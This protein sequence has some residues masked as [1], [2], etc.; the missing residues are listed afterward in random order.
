VWE[1]AVKEIKKMESAHDRRTFLER[2]SF[3]AAVLAS[4]RPGAAATASA[5]K[6]LAGVFPIGFSPFTAGDKLDLDGLASQVKF[7][8][9]GGVRG[10]VWPQIAS[11]WTTLSEKERLDGAEAIVAAGKGGATALVIGVQAGV[12]APDMAA[13]LRLAKH[14]AKVGADAI[15]SLPPDGQNDDQT[16]LDFYQQIG[17]AT[18]LPLFVQSTGSMSVDLL[19]EMLRTIPTFRHVKDEAG[20]PLERVTDIRARSGDRLKVFSGF[21]VQTMITEMELGFSGHCPFVS[22]AD[23]YSSAYDLWH[24]GQ[25]RA[26]FD[27]FGRIQA[28]NSMVPTNSF[29]VL[30]ARGVLKPGVRAREAAAV[31]AASPPR[32]RAPAMTIEEIQATLKTYLQPYLRG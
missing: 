10:F 9:R 30:I 25:K 8:N 13:I 23:I 28:L 29:D 2:F 32:R 15:V 31:A 7:C 18:Q 12:Q 24:S 22:V 4:L 20:D 14:A 17:R 6:K 21:G 5:G 19:L 3:G 27:M 11:A 1:V 26:A 16:L